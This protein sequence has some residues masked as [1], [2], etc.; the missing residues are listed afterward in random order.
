MYSTDTDYKYITA[1]VNNI[2][3]AGEIGENTTIIAR[4]YVVLKD[5]YHAD[6]SPQVIYGQY[7][8]FSSG[9]D[10]CACSGSYR[11]I[12]SLAAAQ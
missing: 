5:E 3:N 4:P 6:G 7:V 12:K 2:Q 8:D 9:E 1:S 11:Y 10:Y